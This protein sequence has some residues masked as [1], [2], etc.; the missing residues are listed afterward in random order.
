[1]TSTA[2]VRRVD[3]ANPGTDANGFEVDG[4]TEV[5]AGPFRVAGSANAAQSRRADVG[6]V[7]INLAVRIAHFP[8]STAGL[9]DGDVVEVTGGENAG[10]FLRIVEASWQDQATSRRVP[11]IETQRPGGWT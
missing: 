2:L 9:R 6:D 7:E 1:M 4:W 11:V 5:Y 3:P 8:A 10:A